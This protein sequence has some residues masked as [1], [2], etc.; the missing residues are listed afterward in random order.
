MISAQTQVYHPSSQKRK[1]PVDMV[2]KPLAVN[3]IAFEDPNENKEWTQMPEVEESMQSLEN[4]TWPNNLP[5]TMMPA[6]CKASTSKTIDFYQKQLESPEIAKTQIKTKGARNGIL[7]LSNYKPKD[8]GNSSIHLTVDGG[9]HLLTDNMPPVPVT[10][11]VVES[12]FIDP[13]F[14]HKE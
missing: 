3:K 9:Q 7:L 4:K 8:F 6:S 12:V 2:P 13:V 1:R 10:S 11:K 14:D 5:K